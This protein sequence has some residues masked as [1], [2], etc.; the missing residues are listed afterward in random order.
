[1]MNRTQNTQTH[2]AV[3]RLHIVKN[4]NRP[5]N[6]VY[7]P[8]RIGIVGFGDTATVLITPQE[9]F[10]AR[11]QEV[12]QNL[13]QKVKG[14]TNMTD[15]LRKSLELIRRV[16]HGILRRI[17][18]L[19][20]GHP[21]IERETLMDMVEHARQ[22][23]C[24]INTI[25]FGNSSNYD[26]GLLRRISAGTHNGKFVAVATLQQLTEA[27]VRGAKGPSGPTQRHH[28]SETSVLAIDLSI[29]MSESMEETT[30]IAVV[31]KAVLQLLHYKQRCF[32]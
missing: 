2:H 14:C 21:N 12:S 10:S 20:D 1:M 26:E 29:S 5:G 24:N 3:N 19:S 13:H 32:S 16:P 28:R 6:R 30:K 23:H 15:G 27:L 25:G 9:P 8:D 11:L 17:W 22:A 4:Q 7:A 18:L 31:E